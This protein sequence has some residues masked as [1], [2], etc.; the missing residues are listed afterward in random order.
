MKVT[1]IIVSAG[2]V[3]SHPTEQYANLR[4]Q[5][6]IKATIDDGED[7]EAVT[8]AMQAKVEKLIEDHKN[9]LVEQILEMDR[10]RHEDAEIANLESGI[11]ESQVRLERLRSGRQSQLSAGQEDE[12]KYV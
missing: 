4:P 1:E 10:M 12:G 3:V 11:Q 7:Y 6:T 8:K 9:S 5:L 2:R